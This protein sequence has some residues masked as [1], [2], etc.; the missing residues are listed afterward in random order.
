MA[1]AARVELAH[2]AD[3]PAGAEIPDMVVGGRQQ[4][5]RQCLQ[6]IEHRRIGSM[7]K[8]AVTRRRLGQRSPDRGLQIGKADIRPP[9][10]LSQSREI[11][12]RI[13]AQIMTDQ[14]LT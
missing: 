3:N 4:R 2:H 5:H 8:H 6:A 12:P 9:A 7:Q 10:D 1:E 11:G 13:G 14:R